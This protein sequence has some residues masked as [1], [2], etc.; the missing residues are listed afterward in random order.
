MYNFFF[1]SFSLLKKFLESNP[2]KTP[3]V[4]DEANRYTVYDAPLSLSQELNQ[5]YVFPFF[6]EPN[7]EIYIPPRKILLSPN[8]RFILF[9]GALYQQ[10]RALLV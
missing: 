4:V 3:S 9:L 2:S 5:I 10:H 6:I 7:K 8:K 1:F